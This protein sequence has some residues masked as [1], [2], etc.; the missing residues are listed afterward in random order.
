MEEAREAVDEGTLHYLPE[1]D[2]DWQAKLEEGTREEDEVTE[3]PKAGGAQGATALLEELSDDGLKRAA[4][5]KRNPMK[6][7]R[8]KDPKGKAPSRS[9][10]SSSSS[11]TSSSSSDSTSSNQKEME[12][13]LVD[14]INTKFESD[15]TV[16]IEE[17][18]RKE[19]FTCEEVQHLKKND[20]SGVAKKC[21]EGRA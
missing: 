6:R 15:A 3:E 5:A 13:F 18:K 11:G 17:L 14:F 9:S 1:D 2:A 8:P 21:G 4:T 19:F 20:M 12:K 10:S 16:I 7:R